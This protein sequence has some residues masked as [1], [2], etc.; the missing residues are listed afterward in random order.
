MF[1]DTEFEREIIDRNIRT[2]ALRL[3]IGNGELMLHYQPQVDM[4][5]GRVLGVEALVRWNHPTDG[6]LP[7]ASFLDL[8]QDDEQLG[9]ALTQWVLNQALNDLERLR[10]LGYTLGMSVNIIIPALESM[11][12]VFLDYLR[13]MLRQH[14]SLEPELLILEIV[15]NVLI[16]DL[17]KATSTINQMQKLGLKISLDDFGTGFSSLSYL[18]HLSFD[19]LK[20]D[21]GFVRDMLHDREDMTIVQ[22]VI[23]LSQS[24]GVPVIAEGVETARHADMLLRLGCTRAQGYAISRPLAIDALVIWLRDWRPAPEWK[25]IAPMSSHFYPVASMLSAHIGWGES[26]EKYL[27]K[28]LVDPPILEMN[29]CEFGAILSLHQSTAERDDFSQKAIHCHEAL[30]AAGV[31]V[32]A[33]HQSADDAQAQVQLAQAVILSK[34]L[35][36]LIL[37]HLQ[38]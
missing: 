15:E 16:D 18:K 21:Q 17:S 10:D 36:T 7:P 11:R 1:F 32:L 3:A 26:L 9:M 30:H 8:I 22:A 29:A 6:L 38:F 24:F 33:A 14:A 27:R 34:K 25:H 20:I 19:E 31:A 23:S 12:A 2:E 13:K 4:A 35:Q 28:E 37:E 5:A